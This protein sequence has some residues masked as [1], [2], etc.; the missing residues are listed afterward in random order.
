MTRESYVVHQ[1][2]I[3]GHVS[4][5]SDVSDVEKNQ[6][7]KLGKM[8][9]ITQNTKNGLIN[10]FQNRIYYSFLIYRVIKKRRI[11]EFG[12]SSDC[13]IKLMDIG[14]CHKSKGGILR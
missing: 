11:L 1:A 7:V 13:M 4:Y 6:L 2:S 5:E 9:S 14:N 8:S 10:L 3:S 12:D